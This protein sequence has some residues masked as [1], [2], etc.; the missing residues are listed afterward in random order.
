MNCEREERK[1]KKEVRR[2]PRGQAGGGDKGGLQARERKEAKGRAEMEG[3]K[4][5]GEGR[6]GGMK[7]WREG[8]LREAG[9][10]EWRVQQGGKSKNHR[11]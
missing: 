5:G 4:G 11:T 1:W 8:S 6:E 2:E 9:S 3:R 10:G 7:E